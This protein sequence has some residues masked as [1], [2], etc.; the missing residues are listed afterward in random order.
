MYFIEKLT[1]YSWVFYIYPY[2]LGRPR[3]SSLKLYYI[4]A[5]PSGLWLSCLMAGS[6]KAEINRLD[7]TFFT[8]KDQNGEALWWKAWHGD[9][10]DLLK[11]MNN[12]PEIQE[13]TQK[14]DQRGI[15]R[16]FL[17]K[18]VLIPDNITHS[19][20]SLL[21]LLQIL[22]ALRVFSF[23]AGN[24]SEKTV[25]IFLISSQRP[26]LDK[27]SQWAKMRNIN[28]IPMKIGGFSIKGMLMKASWLRVLSSK[29]CMV[30]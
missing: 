1:V 14:Y 4:N 23:K 16:L 20:F 7:F 26:W 21:N 19:N 9:F 28:I 17:T 12:L 18:R 13:I 5:S 15:L 29:R 22:F 3:Q 11:Y 6:I 25:D 24:E 10:L 8:A 27:F 30:G 2:F